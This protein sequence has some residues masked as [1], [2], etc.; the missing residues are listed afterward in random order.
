MEKTDRSDHL[1]ELL[2]ERTLDLV[3]QEGRD[4]SLR[5]IAILLVCEAADDR[6]T[7]RGLAVHLAITKPAVI[8]AV[9]RLQAA[10]LARRKADPS[11]R[12][13]VL[14]APTPA[15]RRYALQFFGQTRPETRAVAAK[16]RA[17][18][19]TALPQ[20]PCQAL[21]SPAQ[22]R[23]ARDLLEWSQS[24]LASMAEMTTKSIAKFELGGLPL[25]PGDLQAM[26]AAIEAAGVIFMDENGHGP[27]VRLRKADSG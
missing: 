14:F 27:G 25:P 1:L 19:A 5:Q 7:V 2:L 23:E 8:R 26:R 20:H 22:V 21:I 17:S 4:L 11:D 12:R 24:R 16:V 9:N 13:S 10:G 15:G 3:R 18:A 6:Q